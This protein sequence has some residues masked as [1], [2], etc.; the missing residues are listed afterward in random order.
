MISAGRADVYCGHGDD[1]SF[2]IAVRDGDRRIVVK[3]SAS[4]IAPRVGYDEREDAARRFADRIV[5]AINR[6]GAQ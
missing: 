5:D 4:S 1:Y 2:A 6:G 3:A